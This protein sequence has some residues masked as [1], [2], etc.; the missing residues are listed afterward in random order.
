MV[1]VAQQSAH[2]NYTESYIRYWSITCIWN[3]IQCSESLSTRVIMACQFFETN[4]LRRESDS[5][6]RG[7][8]TY[9]L[10]TIAINLKSQFN[11]KKEISTFKSMKMFACSTIVIFVF[12]SIS[13]EAN[14]IYVT[15]NSIRECSNTLIVQFWTKPYGSE[16]FSLTWRLL[17]LS[18]QK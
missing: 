8:R 14:T 5:V 13:T 12:C 9:L 1:L 2:I 11:Q 6:K 18:T 7:N 4:I 3:L 17:E 15:W 10:N 16:I